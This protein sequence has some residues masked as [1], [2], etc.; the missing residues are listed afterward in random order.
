VTAFIRVGVVTVAVLAILASSPAVQTLAVG[1]TRAAG[2]QGTPSIRHLVP[3]PDSSGE[4]PKRFEWT[5]VKGADRYAIS[6]FNEI[7]TTVWEQDDMREPRVDWPKDL[8]VDTGTYFWVVA[9]LK[10]DRPIAQSGR[11]AFVVLR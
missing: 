5:P 11:A 3:E 4:A 8:R 1:I 10:D 7:D 6:V 2:E 9:A